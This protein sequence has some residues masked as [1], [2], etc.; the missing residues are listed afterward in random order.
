VI[1]LGTSGFSYDDWVGPV[2]PVDL[3]RREWLGFYAREFDTLELNVTFYRVPDLRTVSGWVER[4]PPDFTFAVKANRTLTHEREAAD[5]PGFRLGIAPLIDSGKLACVLAQF[6]HSF[7]PDPENRSYLSRLRDG[8]EGLPVVVELRDRGWVTEETF[9]ELSRLGFGY[10]SVD[11]PNLRGLMPSI[12]KATG[13]L[14]YVRFH[15]RNAEKWWDHEFA[16]ERYDYTYSEDELREWVPKLRGLEAE[17]E[18]VLVYANN[19]Y[20]GQSLDTIRKLKEM[21]GAAR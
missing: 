10:C 7:H 9:Q 2:Y 14:S 3:P 17:S 11:E 18:A 6:P 12:A 13:P 8:L 21:L 5:F 4:T 19:H 20:R 1:R 16:W 15:G